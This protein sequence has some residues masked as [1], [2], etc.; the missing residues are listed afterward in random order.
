MKLNNEELRKVISEKGLKVTP[1]R[2][3]VLRAVLE[4]GTHPTAEQIEDALKASFMVMS[5]GTLYKVLDALVANGLIKRVKTDRD[6]LRYDGN[7]K[8]HHHLYCS[9]CDLIEDYEDEELDELL[10]AHFA[11]KKL[12]GFELEEIVVQVRGAF[13]K[14]S[15]NQ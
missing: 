1:Q 10:K 6:I 13:K 12:E 9:E 3:A 8:S 7:L 15:V 11:K 2:M 14:C 4:S 5:K